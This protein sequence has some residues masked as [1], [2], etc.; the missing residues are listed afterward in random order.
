[1]AFLTCWSITNLPEDV[2]EIMERDLQ[3]WDEHAQ[4]SALRNSEIDKVVRDSKNFWVPTDN[5]IAG[6]LW[7]YIAKANRENFQY[8]LLDIDNGHIQYTQYGEGQF[9]NWHQ[10]GDID[11]YYKPQLAASSG[12]N[13]GNDNMTLGGENVR[14]LSCLDRDWETSMS[15]TWCQL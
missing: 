11:V 1:M 12:I 7:Y 5:W 8:D 10:D 14:K 3:Q 9:Y 2:V 4:D 13:Q 15:P 6:F